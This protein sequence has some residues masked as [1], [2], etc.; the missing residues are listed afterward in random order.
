[1]IK[2]PMKAPSKG[3]PIGDVEA[4]LAKG[5]VACSPKVD[6]I[7]GIKTPKGMLSNSLKPLGNKFMQKELA[8][9]SLNGLDGELTVGLPHNDLSLPDDDV[10]NRTSGAIRRG[11][12]EP[13]FTFWVFDQFMDKTWSYQ[14]RWLD[15]PYPAQINHPRVCILPQ[16]LCTTIEQV[17]DYEAECLNQG[18]EGIMVRLASGHYKE[19]RATEKEGLLLKRKPLE[20]REAKIV[21]VFEQMENQN[22]KTTNE[23]GN[24]TRSSHK[25][26]K[27]GKDTLGGWI[28]QDDHWINEENP[29]GLFRCGTIIGGTKEWRKQMWENYKQHPKAFH[30]KIV[31]YLYQGVGSIDKPR[32]PRCKAEFRGPEDMTP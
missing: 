27:A 11:S 20:Q 29:E 2:H 30:S 16:I 9:G 17:L 32:Q 26:N 8:C 24:S 13:D 4:M 23:L 6:G 22:E 21:D 5:I 31:T 15:H 12:G 18:Y 10:F 1:M 14:K 25:E 19:G 7:R 28:L 3:S